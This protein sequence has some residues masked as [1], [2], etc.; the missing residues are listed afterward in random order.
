MKIMYEDNTNIQNKMWTLIKSENRLLN[1]CFRYVRY[2]EFVSTNMNSELK[3]VL[4]LLG[5]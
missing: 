4:S 3:F 2:N 1:I 5:K